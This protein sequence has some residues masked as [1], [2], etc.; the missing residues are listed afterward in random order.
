M[1]KNVHSVSRHVFDLSVDL[2]N[3]R[4][5]CDFGCRIEVI[6]VLDLVHKKCLRAQEQVWN[7]NTLKSL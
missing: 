1:V 2:L 3:F 6:T 7:A 4:K 5:L